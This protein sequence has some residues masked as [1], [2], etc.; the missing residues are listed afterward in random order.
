MTIV[1]SGVFVYSSNLSNVFLSYLFWVVVAG[2]TGSEGPGLIGYLSSIIAFSTIVSTGTL[3]GMPLSIQRLVGRAMAQNDNA[4]VSSL[5]ISAFCLVFLLTVAAALAILLL[6]EPIMSVTGFS[7]DLLLISLIIIF[8]LVTYQVLYSILLSIDRSKFILL[9]TLIQGVSKVLIIIFLISGSFEVGALLLSFVFSYVASIT[10]MSAPL[11][12]RLRDGL[13]TRVFHGWRLLIHAGMSN[14]VPSM[15]SAIGGQLSVLS[16]FGYIGAAQAGEYYMASAIFSAVVGL[17]TALFSAAFPVLSGMTDARK[18]L[19]WKLTKYSLLIS[20]PLTILIGLYANEILT[21]L[22]PNLI[23]AVIPQRILLIGVVPAII[24][25][26]IY[27]LLYANGK[28]KSILVSGLVENL[29]RISLYLLLV[30]SFGASGAAASY[31]SGS[32]LSMLFM[33]LTQRQYF[34][35]SWKRILAIVSI[36]TATGLA[37]FYLSIAPMI[38]VPIVLLACVFFYLRL[39]MAKTDEIRGI[40]FSLMPAYL[41]SNVFRRLEKIV[42]FVGKSQLFNDNDRI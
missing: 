10:V 9:G 2:L 14:W 30:P 1:K 5:S 40:V 39:D 7:W 20:A 32:F 41:A 8:E 31:I 33:V 18:T 35:M 42:L 21:M 11:I 26:G 34:M 16:V 23:N 13:R 27:Y 12:K 29:S 25:Y 17:P 15:V 19:S 24:N 28:Y 4:S 38:G 36:P 37:L 22:N 6:S 3:L